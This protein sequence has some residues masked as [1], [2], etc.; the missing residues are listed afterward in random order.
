MQ[1]MYVCMCVC[2]YV[3]MYVYTHHGSNS[4]G[5]KD[6]IKLLGCADIKSKY[7]SERG[8]ERQEDGWMEGRKEGTKGSQGSQEGKK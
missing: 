6:N 3:C 5:R 1:Y 4:M 8:K 7:W 2:I